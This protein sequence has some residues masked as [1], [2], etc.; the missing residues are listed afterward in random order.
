MSSGLFEMLPTNYSFT[1]MYNLAINNLQGLICHKTQPT[2]LVL[3][4][5]IRGFLSHVS[6]NAMER[7][8]TSLRFSWIRHWTIWWWG[9]NFGNLGVWSISSLPVLP[10]PLWP[11]AVALDW[12]LSMGQIEQIVCKQMTDV[13]LWLLNSN[14][15]NHLTVCKTDQVR[16]RMLSTKCLQLISV[17]GIK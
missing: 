15:W 12:F 17:F 5:F 7:S 4:V 11:G 9:S 3:S 8:K 16:L 14:T 13:K 2:N 6:H 10:G 1:N